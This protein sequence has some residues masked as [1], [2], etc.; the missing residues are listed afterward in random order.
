VKKS[1]KDNIE[2]K[3]DESKSVEIEEIDPFEELEKE[4]REKVIADLMDQILS[5]DIFH[6]T[7][8]K[9]SKPI[10]MLLPFEGKNQ[11]YFFSPTLQIFRMVRA[12]TEA[13]VIEESKGGETL[14]LIHDVPY[15]VPDKY[16]K[17]VG[18]N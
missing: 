15:M 13:I 2:Q 8:D 11:F 6:E 18:Y 17:N 14:C 3:S 9:L 12:P 5:S 1:K 16:L 7:F 10:T 4:E